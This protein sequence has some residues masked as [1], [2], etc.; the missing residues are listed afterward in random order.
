VLLP[1]LRQ[2]RREAKATECISNLRQ[3]GM[4]MTMYLHGYGRY[5]DAERF[6][7]P[8][9]PRSIVTLLSPYLDC[10]SIFVSPLSENPFREAGL[11]YVFN[12]EADPK[13][14]RHEWLLRS[15]RLP[16]RPNPGGRVGILFSD[17]SVVGVREDTEIALVAENTVSREEVASAEEI[18]QAIASGSGAV[19]GGVIFRIEFREVVLPDSNPAPPIALGYDP[20][21]EHYKLTIYPP[22][23][24]FCRVWWKIKNVDG[25]LVY[26]RVGLPT[27]PNVVHTISWDGRWSEFLHEGSF[28]S[29]HRNPYTSHLFAEF[30]G[31]V[32]HTEL[33]LPTIY[34]HAAGGMG[35]CPKFFGND[36]LFWI[37]IL[38]PLGALGGG[39]RR[40]L[41]NLGYHEVHTKHIELT[42][43]D[44]VE[45]WRPL[46]PARRLIWYLLAHGCPDGTLWEWDGGVGIQPAF[47]FLY[48]T[49]RPLLSLACHLFPPIDFKLVHLGACYVGLWKESWS[50]RF[51]DAPIFSYAGEVLIA[52]TI[53]Y[54][55]EL[56]EAL[57]KVDPAGR[58]VP[59][60]YGFARIW[61]EFLDQEGRTELD[62]ARPIYYVPL[63]KEN[64][65]IKLH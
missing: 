31:V 13:G 50:G 64:V 29:A 3:I 34:A 41:E 20:I 39:A 14:V 32:L 7:L 44:I 58:S 48:F 16:G 57:N 65:R 2:A 63:G 37:T 10:T 43:E 59:V 5:P 9:H 4:A 46:T 55:W 49:H 52:H 25:T 22:T 11:S 21:V 12:T 60:G 17:G 35:R 28:V 40:Q 33:T 6:A 8:P 62:R 56:F 42:Q 61:E 26:H 24:V 47:P 27:T 30:R 15:A 1:T 54:K 18:A 19:V 45:P 36:L 51:G 38:E 53:E 23:P